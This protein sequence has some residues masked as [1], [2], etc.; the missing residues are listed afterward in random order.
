MR[1]LA[2]GLALCAL[3]NAVLAV[4]RRQAPAVDEVGIRLDERGALESAALFGVGMRRLASDLGIIRMLLY[5]GG[6]EDDLPVGQ[7]DGSHD[8][9]EGHRHYGSFDPEHPERHYGGGRYQRLGPMAMRILDLDPS[10]SYAALFAAGALAFNLNRPDE[11][12]GVIDYGL[13]RD[14][15]NLQY[16]RYAAAVGCHRRGNPEEV[17]RIMEP[18]LLDP[19]CPTMIKNLLAFLYYRSGKKDKAVRLYT[20]IYEN[21]RDQGYRDLARR[22][23]GRLGAG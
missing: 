8:G 20:D 21:T 2:A 19:D 6:E 23:L 16:Q 5:Y 4:S 22:M 13:K 15:K 9:H 12:L 17:I 1:L 18:V 3:L 11:A 14:P 7:D 10:F